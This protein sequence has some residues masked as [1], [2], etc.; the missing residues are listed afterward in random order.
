[1]QAGLDQRIELR[2]QD[3]IELDDVDAFDCAWVPTFFVT[4]ERLEGSLPSLFRSL[5]PGGLVALGRMRT[6]PDPLAEAT[7]SLRTIR[8]G[9]VELDTKR[10]VE[11]LEQ[12]GFV[13]EEATPS[14]LPIPLELILGRRP[15]T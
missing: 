9:G 2:Q 13:T 10:A 11:L 4:E 6:A 15:T 8:A 3:V 5:R 12:A 14:G 1:M 7:S